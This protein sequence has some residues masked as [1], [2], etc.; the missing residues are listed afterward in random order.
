[1]DRQTILIFGGPD[2][3]GKTTIAKEMARQLQIPYFKPAHQQIIAETSP[4]TFALQTRHGEPKLLDFVQQT[5]YSVIMDRSFP[6]DWVYSKVLGRET[7]WNAIQLLDEAYATLNAKL[8]F[9]VKTKTGYERPIPDSWKKITNDVLR[10]LD[11]HYRVYARDSAMDAL[12]LDTTDED[13]FR[14]TNAIRNFIQE[15]NE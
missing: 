2:K 15:T 6:C 7:A 10:D 5:G 3:C 13:L 11:A 14:Q 9:C 1:M 4:E 8:I 12:V